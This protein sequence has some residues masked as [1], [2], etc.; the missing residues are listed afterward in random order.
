VFFRDADPPGVKELEIQKVLSVFVY[1][2][3][4]Q[5]PLLAVSEASTKVAFTAR[6]SLQRFSSD[7]N[8]YIVFRM[9]VDFTVFGK[10]NET[11]QNIGLSLQQTLHS[12]QLYSLLHL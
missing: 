3:R 11:S 8:Y 2:C 4:W 10:V 5:L 12:S 7:T 1:R 9:C 6:P